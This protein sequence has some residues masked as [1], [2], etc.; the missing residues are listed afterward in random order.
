MIVF[1]IV[2][3]LLIMIYLL[4]I[5]LRDKVDLEPLLASALLKL[6]KK[7]PLCRHSH[8]INEINNKKLSKY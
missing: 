2:L 5:K 8:N 6:H 1:T 7:G 3:L 4:R